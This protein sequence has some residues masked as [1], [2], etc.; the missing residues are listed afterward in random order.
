MEAKHTSVPNV[1]DLLLN[2]PDAQVTRCKLAWR[3]VADGEWIDA[4][5]YLRN[6]VREEEGSAWAA[7]A[8]AMADACSRNSTQA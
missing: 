3:A 8:T 7:Q 5:H 1:Y 6:A 4:E 2:A